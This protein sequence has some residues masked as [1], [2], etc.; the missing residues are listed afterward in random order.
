MRFACDVMLGKLAKYLRILGFDATYP[1]VDVAL[2]ELYDQEDPRVFLT[3]RRKAFA[4]ER[5]VYIRLENV[6]EQLKE[7]K[8]LIKPF[9]DPDKVLSRCINCNVLLT[10]VEKETIEHR[11]PEFVFHTYTAFKV[12]PRCDRVYWAG[13]HANHMSQLIEEITS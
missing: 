13:T 2:S 6:R 10:D 1:L 5:T 3:R 4:Y 8:E 7:V 12:C 11:V 9:I